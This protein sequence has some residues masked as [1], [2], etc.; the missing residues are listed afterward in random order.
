VEWKNLNGYI[1]GW[2][3]DGM[4]NPMT[5]CIELSFMN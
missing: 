4:K 3:K 1:Y 2:R 5:I